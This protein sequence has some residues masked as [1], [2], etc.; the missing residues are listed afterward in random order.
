M[1]Q[2]HLLKTH[3]NFLSRFYDLSD[4]FF[5]KFRYKQIR[6]IVWSHARGK[7]LDLGVGTGQNIPYYPNHFAKTVGVDLS[8]GMILRAKK[9]ASLSGKSVEFYQMDATALN[10]SDNSFDS[11]VSTFMFCVLPN[12]YQLQALHECCR[13]LK[14]GGRL[15]LLEYTYSNN[16]FRKLW[17]KILSPY[18]AL[19]YKAG[20][21]RITMDF[22]K[23]SNMWKLE[24]DQF[25]YKDIIR[26][27]VVQKI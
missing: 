17:M 22:L 13:V 3:Y 7:T 11:I 15:I 10:F 24:T 1:N 27:V 20:F 5:E 12:E 23:L 19:V 6:P 21:N 18:L 9:R 4:W 25:L 14:T 26:L 16:F 2:L 8:E